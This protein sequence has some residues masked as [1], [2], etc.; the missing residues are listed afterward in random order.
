M[1]KLLKGYMLES[2]PILSIGIVSYN[3]LDYLKKCLKSVSLSQE[4]VSFEIIVVDNH[5]QEDNV[6][7]I[8]KNYP[9]I[10]LI[11]NSQ[12]LF[13]ATALNQALSIAKGD[14]FLS[15]NPDTEITSG[16]LTKMV[17]YLQEH[18]QIGVL[19]CRLL[20]SDGSLQFSIGNYLNIFNLLNE[21]SFFFKI[22]FRLNYNSLVRKHSF[23][24]KVDSLLGACLLIRKQV[25]QEV[26][27]FDEY[28]RFYAEE[29]DFLYRVTQRKWQVYYLS[30]VAIY[31]HSNKSAAQTKLQRIFSLEENLKSQLRFFIKHRTK[32][33][34]FLSRVILLFSLS[35]RLGINYCFRIMRP[36]R[37]KELNQAKIASFGKTIKWIWKDSHQEQWNIYDHYMPV[38]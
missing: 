16:S 19:G 31:H 11:K 37:E 22:Y 21:Y 20:N 26:G 34:I 3:A 1:V 32:I 28:F 6:N 5:S 14:F 17:Y 33:E 29:V 24:H 27:P 25:I 18:H 13:F 7:F 35:I 8:Q 12:N 38:K 4:S 30:E 9:S 36:H 10:T 2:K 15:L 23:N